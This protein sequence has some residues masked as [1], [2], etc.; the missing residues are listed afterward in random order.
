MLPH[1]TTPPSTL[2]THPTPNPTST[3]TLA[4]GF[5]PG[6]RR[7]DPQGAA[8]RPRDPRLPRWRLGRRRGNRDPQDL[9]SPAF[10]QV[11]RS[12]VSRKDQLANFTASLNSLYQDEII[13]VGCCSSKEGVLLTDQA[14]CQCQNEKKNYFI[15]ALKIGR[16]SKKTN[17]YIY[18]Y[19]S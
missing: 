7:A 1:T 12:I 16:N 11:F 19:M 2:N 18:I 13:Q 6:R 10:P 4:R 3:R 9:S 5:R 15:L 14:H 8:P 17:L